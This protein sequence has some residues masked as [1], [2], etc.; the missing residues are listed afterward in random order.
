MIASRLG[1]NILSVYWKIFRDRGVTTA[2]IL[3]FSSVATLPL[4]L[5]ILAYNVYTGITLPS[6]IYLLVLAAWMVMIFATHFLAI[7]LYK[8]QS[9]TASDSFRIV[10]GSLLALLIDTIIFKS[11]LSP[12]IL[13]GC[14]LMLIAAL[15][16]QRARNPEKQHEKF[17]NIGQILLINC[18]LGAVSVCEIALYKYGLNLLA[19]DIIQQ[20]FWTNSLQVLVYLLWGGSELHRA[21]QKK[22]FKIK[23][24]IVTTFIMCSALIAYTYAIGALPVLVIALIR[25]AGSGIFAIFDVRLKEF[26]LNKKTIVALMAVL[27]GLGLIT[28]GNMD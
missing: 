2:A 12:L 3:A 9:L 18:V 24:M 10:F 5:V 17:Q 4:I 21:V 6:Q 26:T 20:I 25:V 23:D 11:A 16:L 14:G 27:L 15:T 19:G 1:F 13:S 7:F 22:T 8:Y 28:L